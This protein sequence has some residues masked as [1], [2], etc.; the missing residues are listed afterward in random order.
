MANPKP[1]LS[2]ATQF[3][4]GQAP[5]NPGGKPVGARNRLQGKFLNAL[6]DDFDQHG[7]KA[8]RDMREN[9]PSGY[10]KAIASLMPKEIEVTRPLEDMSDDE[11]VANVA[12]L[13]AYLA[14][15][16]AR[17]GDSDKGR[18]KQAKKLPAV[19]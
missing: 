19:H 6:A 4:P 16:G 5:L 3:K 2:P 11:L 7:V 18:P 15:Q 10:V 13:H 1:N 17:A 12:A 8:I 14:S 9:D